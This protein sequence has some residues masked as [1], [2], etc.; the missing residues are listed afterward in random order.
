MKKL[1][2]LL[3]QYFSRRADNGKTFEEA[4]VPSGANRM[5]RSRYKKSGQNS[6]SLNF[7]RLG[8]PLFL[9]FSR[10]SSLFPPRLTPPLPP[11]YS[12]R[13]QIP[14]YKVEV[15]QIPHPRC[16]L[17]SHVNEAVEAETRTNPP[18][19]NPY[20]RSLGGEP[21][22]FTLLSWPFSLLFSFIFF[23]CYRQAKRRAD[24][25][26]GERASSSG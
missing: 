24:I 12:P 9:P 8:F 7:Q 25:K 21:Q 16:N 5:L 6:N 18:T 13:S 22:I 17:R 20:I 23:F 11:L 10:P 19:V 2:R 3:K 4:K 15:L 14:M 26:C 1:C